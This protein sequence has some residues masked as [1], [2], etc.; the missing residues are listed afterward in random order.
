M[1]VFRRLIRRFVRVPAT[2]GPNSATSGEIAIYK[3]SMSRAFPAIL[4][5]LPDTLKRNRIGAVFLLDSVVSLQEA[6]IKQFLVSRLHPPPASDG[7][8]KT[9]LEISEVQR[10]V[11]WAIQ[12]CLTKWRKKTDT[13]RHNG[14]SVETSSEIVVLLEQMR[15]FH[16]EA[17]LDEEYIKEY[18]LDSEQ[19]LNQGGL[20]LV[21]RAMFP[22]AL[23]LMQEIR[24]HYGRESLQEYGDASIKRAIALVKKNDSVAQHFHGGLRQLPGYADKDIAADLLSELHDRLLMKVFHARINESLKQYK[25]TEMGKTT[26]QKGVT[27]VPFRTK[28][29][30]NEERKTTKGKDE[31]PEESKV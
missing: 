8:N 13:G 20:T 23:H 1:I 9:V 28:L 18:Y 14:E 25:A 27:A 17:M 7:K 21:A 31:V 16:R 29:L 4:D 12:D 3:F 10:Y 6:W 5:F 19:I 15:L 22:W 30:A 26:G 11:G 24:K 2:Q